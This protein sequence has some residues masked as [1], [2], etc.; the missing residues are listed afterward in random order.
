MLGRT[1]YKRRV[2][3]YNYYFCILDNKKTVEILIIAM[4]TDIF[5]YFNTFNAIIS[6]KSIG[7]SYYC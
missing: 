3:K 1:V 4:L 6:E 5:Q 7:D 2:Y